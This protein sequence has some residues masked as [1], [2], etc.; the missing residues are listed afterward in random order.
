MNNSFISEGISQTEEYFGVVE[1]YDSEF[2]EKG[3]RGR[4]K[5]YVGEEIKHLSSFKIIEVFEKDIKSSI[6]KTSK[7]AALIVENEIVK[8]KISIGPYGFQ[9][10]DVIVVCMTS[11]KTDSDL[12]EMMMRF[13]KNKTSY[14]APNGSRI[15]EYAHHRHIPESHIAPVEEKLPKIIR[16]SQEEYEQ[17]T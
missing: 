11:R 14:G 16:V 10:S 6:E 2:D 3:G 5:A 12:R 13:C 9:A 8:F 1:F 4:I 17:K 15:K 7:E